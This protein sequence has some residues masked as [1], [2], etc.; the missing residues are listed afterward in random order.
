MKDL[1]GY[2][3]HLITKDEL[4]RFYKQKDWKQLRDAVL[5]DYHNECAECRK[6]GIITRYDIDADGKKKLI[7]TVHHVNHVREHPELALSRYYYEN[8]ER[9]ENLLPVCKKCH[10]ELH[11]EK[12]YRKK[13]HNE[14][15]FVNE[16][17][18]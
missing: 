7:K 14:K 6:R 12:G 9:K 10:N 13:R 18:W 16:E 3:N 1:V 4:W 17:R 15:K 2:I 5:A 8:G 11:P